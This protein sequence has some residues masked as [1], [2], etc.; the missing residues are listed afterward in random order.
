MDK[1]KKKRI[2]KI[3]TWASIGLLV[4]LLS[5]MPLLARQ[6]A[7]AEGPVAS[8][9]SGTVT[10]GSLTS[11]LHGGGNLEA[12]TVEEVKLPSGVKIEGFLVKNGQFVTE[13]TPLAQVDKVSV[14][15]AIMEVNETIDFLQEEL[16]AARE[17][18]VPSNIRAT[19]GGRVKKLFAAPGESAQEV[20]LRDGALAILSLDGL[21]AVKLERNLSVRTGESVL[22]TLSD[23]REV[24]GRVESNLDST[25][26]ITVE[27]AGYEVGQTVSVT[28]EDGKALGRGQLYIHNAWKAVAF[29]GTIAS[30]NTQEE[31]TLSEGAS[32]FTIKDRD[33]EGELNRRANQHREYEQLLQELFRMYQSGY[34]YAPCDG[35]VEGVDN[36]SVHLLNATPDGWVLAPLNSTT[37]EAEKPWTVMLLSSTGVGLD[38][39]PAQTG[40]CTGKSDCPLPY[41]AHTEEQMAQCEALC[42]D[43]KTNTFLEAHQDTC[44]TWCQRAD[45]TKVCTAKNHYPD[46]IEKC[47]SAKTGESCP[48]A[49]YHKPDC[50]ESCQE[51]DGVKRFC[52]ATGDHKST[53][54]KACTKSED[55]KANPYHYADCIQKCNGTKDCPANVH[56]ENCP[57]AHLTYTAEV[58][59]VKQ[60]E[61]GTILYA[62]ESA[63]GVTAIKNGD[64][65]TIPYKPDA[66][67]MVNGVGSVPAGGISCKVGDIILIVTG[68]DQNGSAIVDRRVYVYSSSAAGGM[69]AMGGMAGFGGMGGFRMDGFSMTGGMT[70]FGNSAM[71]SQPDEGL[72]DLEGSTLLTVTAHDKAKLVISVDEH[73]IARVSVGMKAT[74]KVEALKGRE[75]DA[76]V[77]SIAVSGTNNGGSSKFQV[78]LT[79]PMGENM[80]SGMS[81]SAVIALEEKQD[82]LLIPAVA[83]IQQGAKTLVCTALDQEGN[84]TNAV[85]VTT[86]V[87]DGENVEI[88]SGLEEGQ[89]FYYRYYDTVELDNSVEKKIGSFF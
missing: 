34:L 63:E 77:T 61:S 23:G 70:G 89:T 53:C 14:M 82:T 58:G 44:V 64:G 37:Q 69:G 68:K 41:E 67:V 39:P 48:A 10:R 9:L 86:G 62:Y 47:T 71:S 57:H 24:T 7:E 28:D 35:E 46:C 80:L 13:G 20:M 60:V 81:A 84:P 45:K 38:Q 26:V 65:Y 49:K 1:A 36:D 56:R 88:L 16:E 17:E 29:T 31:K 52:D 75:F 25:V 55:C 3:L 85:E 73:D 4:L 74:V 59:V 2:Q 66:T 22:V 5:A 79:L 50:L 78:T 83:L 12:E 18:T 33:F 43:C 27:D 42:K 11:V 72:F 76:E 19:A 8:I 21:M 30:V 87:S 51:A 6:E 54:I 15:T 40:T 32:L